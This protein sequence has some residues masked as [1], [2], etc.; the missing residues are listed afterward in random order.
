MKEIEKELEIQ[1]MKKKRLSRK[2]S[3]RTRRNHEIL[4][5]FLCRGMY[6]AGIISERRIYETVSG[7]SFPDEA[8]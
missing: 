1:R 2:K 8:L 4:K 3:M 5:L 6:A 7:D